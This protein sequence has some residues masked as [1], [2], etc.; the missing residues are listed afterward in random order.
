LEKFFCFQIIWC[1]P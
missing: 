1:I